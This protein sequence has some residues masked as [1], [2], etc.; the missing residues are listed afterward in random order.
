M[1]KNLTEVVIVLDRSGSMATIKN[2]MENG[3]NMFVEK[4]AKEKG[5]CKISCYT[6]DTLIEKTLDAVDVKECPK[7][8][9]EPR[10]GTSLFDA[11]GK[12]INDV[13][14]RLS[15]TDETER[16]ELVIFLVI[17]DGEENSS[18][19]FTREKINEMI[20]NQEDKYSWK[21]IYLGANQD[22]FANGVKYGIAG[23]SSMT[24]NTSSTGIYNSMNV[25]ASGV[26]CM[27]AFSDQAKNYSFSDNER[28]SAML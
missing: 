16:P 12:S 7:I 25:L 24:Y 14:N 13:G 15:K 6:F 9:L 2:D 20:K 18:K 17:T 1:K 19:E 5:D 10:G 26:S 4:Q 23:G 28:A 3:L 22:A 27:R 8:L 11:L 21:F